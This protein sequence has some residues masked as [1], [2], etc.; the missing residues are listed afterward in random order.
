[1]TEHPK[2]NLLE[3]CPEPGCKL[4]LIDRIDR[5]PTTKVLIGLVS[6]YAAIVGCMLLFASHSLS[7]SVDR[8]ADSVRMNSQENMTHSLKIRDLEL[9]SKDR[10]SDIKLIGLRLQ[11]IENLLMK[12]AKI[13]IE[14]SGK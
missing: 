1:M 13:Q 3:G 2:V 11:N 9:I 10:E 7:M 5:R 12:A 4:D 8:L 6:L 14:N